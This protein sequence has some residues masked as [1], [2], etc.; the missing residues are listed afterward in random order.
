MSSAMMVGE[1]TF[2]EEY[3]RKGLITNETPTSGGGVIIVV[4]LRDRIV[5]QVSKSN[6]E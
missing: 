6:L 5:P 2:N 1:G 3:C 4:I